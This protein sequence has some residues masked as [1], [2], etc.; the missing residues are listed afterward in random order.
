[1]QKY[2]KWIY[3]LIAAVLVIFNFVNENFINKDHLKEYV[4]EIPEFSGSPYVVINNNVPFFTEDEYSFESFEKYS[5]LD[6]LGRNGVA[7]ASIGQDIMPTE[8]RES[9]GMVKPVG[10]HTIKYEWI[11]GKYLYNRC[12][13]LGFQLTGE[14]ANE[15][16]L[17]TGT[18]YL[19]VEGMLPFENLVAEYVKE[20]GYHVLLRVTPVYTNDNL[21]ADGIMMEGLSMED[22][23]EGIT[24]NVYCYNVQPGVIIDYATGKSKKD[25]NYSFENTVLSN[26]TNTYILNTNTKKVHLETCPNAQDIKDKNKDIYHGSLQDLMYKGYDTCSQCITGC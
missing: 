7:F 19:N 17:I 3:L 25:E 15:K 16:N 9:I 10:W 4:S 5:E 13:L 20:T 26:E 2:S 23:G 11:D 12:H 8:E 21:I 6:R 1:M 22:E 18:R 14:N 24:F